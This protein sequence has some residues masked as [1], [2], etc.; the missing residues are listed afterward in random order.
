MLD[1]LIKQ[2]VGLLGVKP[3]PS[4]SRLMSS[5]HTCLAWIAQRPVTA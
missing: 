2:H 3:L 5:M 4:K 1:R